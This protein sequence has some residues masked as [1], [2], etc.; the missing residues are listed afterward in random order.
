MVLPLDDPPLVAYAMSRWTLQR[1]QPRRLRN[2]AAALVLRVPLVAERRPQVSVGQ[3]GTGLP[4]L[5]QA[6]TAHGVPPDARWALTLEGDELSRCI[7][8][9]FDPGADAPR[10]VVK[11]S[12]LRDDP[13]AFDRDERGLSH[14]A[15][16]PQAVLDHVAVMHGRFEV[17]G[18]HASVEAAAPGERLD[19][20]LHR[21]G[22]KPDGLRLIGRIADWIVEL[23]R[24]TVG[25]P[26][27]QAA[28]RRRVAEE[29][30]PRYDLAPGV[31]GELLA[32]GPVPS[33]VEHRDL[34]TWNVV[35]DD[36][37]FT[38]LDWEGATSG[39]FPL[40]DLLYFLTDALA[41]WS[42]PAGPAGR[43]AFT[44]ALL[45]GDSELSPL[46]FERVRGLVSA[47]G[48]APEDVGRLALLS[49]LHHGL[50]HRRRAA[51]AGDLGATATT[52]V[53]PLE[54]VAGLWLADERLGTGW[55][56]WRD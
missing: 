43:D 55:S 13:H 27:A 11:F 47:L 19:V 46:L 5:L 41:T 53:P 48:I 38:V 4:F 34:G 10:L 52:N 42:R 54:R 9:V 35:G 32:L 3:H 51:R 15:G 56:A 8:Y 6:A 33:V 20:Y 1:S 21:R 22:G 40:W 31:A 28:E 18:H 30:V 49:W 14:V 16:A 25:G 36:R 17:D 26:D 2:Q 7:F 37:H 45:R 24:A 44:L 12:R 29:I 50:S 23:A 39:G